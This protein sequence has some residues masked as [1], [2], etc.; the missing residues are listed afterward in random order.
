MS[1]RILSEN[2]HKLITQANEL[3]NYVFSLPAAGLEQRKLADDIMLE[4][5]RLMQMENEWQIMQI[6]QVSL[7]P[8]LIRLAKDINLYNLLIN[9]SKKRNR[10]TSTIKNNYHLGA[11]YE[12][13]TPKNKIELNAVECSQIEKILTELSLLTASWSINE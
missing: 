5:N 4:I 3:H 6:T 1:H 2:L 7:I 9:K 8:K 12:K 11:A 10:T 13:F